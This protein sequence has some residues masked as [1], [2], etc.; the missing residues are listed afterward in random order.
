MEQQRC[1]WVTSDPL[2]LAYHDQEWGVPQYDD[3]VLFE[4]L[5]LEG[6]QAGLSWLTVLKKREAYREVLAGFDPVAIA[7]FDE[8]KLAALL[9]DA[10]LIRNR[11]KM[12]A[13]VKNA[14]AFLTVQAEFGSFSRYIWQFVGGTPLYNHWN[15]LAEVPAVTPQATAMSKDLKRRG[16]TFVGPTICY[17]YMQAVGMVQDHVT[18]CFRYQELTTK[19]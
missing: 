18:T 9:T 11:L 13:L 4:F 3:A 6:L 5:L 17:A 2:Y 7:A 12:A 16:F 19:P 15:S 1:G 14:R 8:A 10:R